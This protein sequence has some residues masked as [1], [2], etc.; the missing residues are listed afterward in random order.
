MIHKYSLLGLMVSLLMGCSQLPQ[1]VSPTALGVLTNTPSQAHITDQIINNG[2]PAM[3]FLISPDANS[4]ALCTDQHAVIWNINLK[5][6]RRQQISEEWGCNKSYAWGP[7][8]QQILYLR[9]TPA[10]TGAG[11]IVRGD[12]A[13]SQAEVIVPDRVTDFALSP[14]GQYLAYIL[15]D[16]STRW[17]LWVMELATSQVGQ[18][19]SGQIGQLFWSGDSA[20][21]LYSLYSPK[22]TQSPPPGGYLGIYQVASGQQKQVTP[23]FQHLGGA[24]W[25][26]DS[27]WIAFTAAKELDH[28]MQVFLVM[29]NGSELRSAGIEQDFSFPIVW[30]PQSDRL[31]FVNRPSGNENGYGLWQHHMDTGTNTLFAQGDFNDAVYSPEGKEV[32]VFQRY[33]R[34][35]VIPAEGGSEINIAETVAEGDGLP[36]FQWLSSTELAYLRI[37]GAIQIQSVP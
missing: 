15:E 10:G 35:L 25:S 28:D 2:L 8:S 30:S 23:V 26:P 11:A 34:L 13:T 19:A 17:T 21:L 31:L 6:G 27:Q 7:K 36:S 32:A 29:A 33:N 22:E 14:D 24:L 9:E 4:M 20:Q 37:D 12:A 5:S 3:R 18:V 1:R 16:T